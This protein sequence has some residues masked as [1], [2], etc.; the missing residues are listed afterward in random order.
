MKIRLQLFF[1]CQQVQLCGAIACTCI[2]RCCNHHDYDSIIPIT[3]W[4]CPV[5]ITNV[6]TLCWR[7]SRQSRSAW[8]RMLHEPSIKTRTRTVEFITQSLSSVHFFVSAEVRDRQVQ[9]KS[10]WD[11]YTRSLVDFSELNQSMATNLFIP[12]EPT[13]NASSFLPYV[14]HDEPFCTSS[15][16][17][18]SSDFN[19]STTKT[20]SNQMSI[21]LDEANVSIITIDPKWAIPSSNDWSFCEIQ[22]SA[23]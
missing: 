10:Y 1:I 13:H 21:S 3:L 4:W 12:F 9:A 15:A 20:R 8:W 5:I 17:S 14:I 6:L 11:E 23:F 7:R 2:W 19:Q 18:V 22:S 16:G